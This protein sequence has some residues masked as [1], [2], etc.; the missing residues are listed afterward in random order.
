M[1]LRVLSDHGI[2][3]RHADAAANVA[4]EVDQGGSLVG[5]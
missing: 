1:H 3:E 4:G 2:G 5:F